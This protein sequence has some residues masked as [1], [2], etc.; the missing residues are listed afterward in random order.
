MKVKLKK[1]KELKE[2]DKDID[3]EHL[4][5]SEDSSYE[6][7]ALFCTPYGNWLT[8]VNDAKAPVH[9]VAEYFRVVEFTI[10]SDWI[11]NST[12]SYPVMM[13][14]DFI[15]KADYNADDFLN[16]APWQKDNFMWY[17]RNNKE[18]DLP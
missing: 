17:L 13:G 4:F 2:V 15:V 11:V 3:L 1:P 6:V 14:P 9:Y 12:E 7:F 18:L 5:L 10:P 16:F 8:L